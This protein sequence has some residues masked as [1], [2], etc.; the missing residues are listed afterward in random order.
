MIQSLWIGKHLTNMEQLAITSFLKNGHRYHLYLYDEVK[1]VPS[2]T[3]LRDAEKIVPSTKIFKNKDRDSYAG[4][5][6]LFRFKLLLDRGGYWVDTD[7]VC[8]KPF[9]FKADFVFVQEPITRKVIPRLLRKYYVNTWFIKAPPDSK[10]IEYCYNEALKI[11]P[12]NMSWGENGPKLFNRAVTE[13]RLRKFISPN[14]AFCPIYARQYRQFTNGSW[15]ASRK[16]RKAQQNA[17]G[18]HLYNEMWRRN[19]IDKNGTFPR[20]SIYEQLK[21]RY[22]SKG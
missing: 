13:F 7:V 22:L 6:D 5:A 14:T 19:G 21:T 1:G 10:L 18:I 11:D 8:L 12:Q 3:V 4:F 20:N 9:K 2:G 17:Y 16:W 15:L